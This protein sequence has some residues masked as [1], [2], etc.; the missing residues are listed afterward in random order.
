MIFFYLA[1]GTGYT[2]DLVHAICCKLH[3][4]FGIS[5]I[6]CPTRIDSYLFFC[7]KSQMRFGV[8]NKLQMQ[9]RVSVI[10]CAIPRPC[11]SFTT[12]NRA[13]NLIAN[14]TANRNTISQHHIACYVYTVAIPNVTAN[15]RYMQQ[16]ASAICSKSDMKSHTK[17]LV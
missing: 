17:S 6:W 3:M 7:S 14:R 13:P 15:R 11:L 2:S 10:W 8:C 1:L 16:I 12:R 4:R 9:F 5:A